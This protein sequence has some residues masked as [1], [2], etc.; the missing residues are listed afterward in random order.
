MKKSYTFLLLLLMVLPLFGQT[1]IRLP[2]LQKGTETGVTI[3]WR[4]DV[5]DPSVVEYSTDVTFAT[6]SRTEKASSTYGAP[7]SFV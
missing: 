1:I 7:F 6:Y 3:K 5:D 2:Y 4:T